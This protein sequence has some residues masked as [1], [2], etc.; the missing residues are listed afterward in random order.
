[1]ILHAYNEVVY[2]GLRGADCRYLLQNVQL[3]VETRVTLAAFWKRVHYCQYLC[4][5]SVITSSLQIYI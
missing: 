4:H 5:V 1:M 3:I 2:I